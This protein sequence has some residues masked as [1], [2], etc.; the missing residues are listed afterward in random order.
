MATAQE[1]M[2][3]ARNQIAERIVELTASL[4][5]DYSENGESV[6][7]SAYLDSLMRQLEKIEEIIQAMG[8]P[9]EQRARGIT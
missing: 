7:N 4:N 2:I 6:Q 1:N 5:P 3:T 9:F 8:G